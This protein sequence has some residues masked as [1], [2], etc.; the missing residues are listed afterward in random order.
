MQYTVPSF[1]I[2]Y[3]LMWF[4]CEFI[5]KDRYIWSE[6]LLK[7]TPVIQWYC[8]AGMDRLCSASLGG[9]FGILMCRR[10]LK[11]NY[12]FTPDLSLL[13]CC[14]LLRNAVEFK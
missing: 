1:Y 2:D 4:Y 14:Q 7:Y 12:S 11:N 3:D 13:L 9:M 8:S 6:A 5:D 10:S